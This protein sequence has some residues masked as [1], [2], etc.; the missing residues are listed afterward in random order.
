MNVKRAY[1]KTKENKAKNKN[2]TNT[3]S[4][5]F[6]AV[7]VLQLFCKLS[8]C[9][10]FRFSCKTFYFVF[11]N[12][13]VIQLPL[14]KK[15]KINKYTDKGAKGNSFGLRSSSTHYFGNY[16]KKSVTLAMWTLSSMY[17][18]TCIHAQLVITNLQS[19]LR[20]NFSQYSQ[21]LTILT[22]FHNYS[23]CVR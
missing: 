16:F 14:T 15:K 20:P 21:F 13:R 1:E 12:Y 10:C 11:Y 6:A 17:I 22:T 18:H 2:K 9:Y 4:L 3:I 19:G 5:T 23:C 7:I 8:P